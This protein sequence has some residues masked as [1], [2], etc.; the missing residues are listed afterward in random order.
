MAP[1]AS[2][3]APRPNINVA[4]FGNFKV[5]VRISS[6]RSAVI[7]FRRLQLSTLALAEHLQMALGNGNYRS[8]PLSVQSSNVHG[9]AV[10]ATTTFKCTLSR[11]TADT[12]GRLPLKLPGPP[13]L[14][15]VQTFWVTSRNIISELD[16]T[17]TQH[18]YVCSLPTRHL[19]RVCLS[20]SQLSAQR[21]TLRCNFS[22]AE[23][24]PCSSVITPGRG[25]NTHRTSIG[26]VRTKVPKLAVISTQ[27]AR[28]TSTYPTPSK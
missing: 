22:D 24:L 4:V 14:D 16:T 27:L 13:P 3:R 5:R 23:P 21:A 15:W 9:S 11:R 1:T 17:T 25:K 7:F 2:Q 19:R 20:R 8:S 26:A 12:A 28:S 18:K 10:L 6:W